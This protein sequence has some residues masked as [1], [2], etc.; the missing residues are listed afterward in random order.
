VVARPVGYLYARTDGS[1]GFYQKT[2]GTGNTGWSAIGGSD[3][4]LGG[5]LGGTASA[6]TVLALDGTAG[7]VPGPSGSDLTIRAALGKAAYLQAKGGGGPSLSLEANGSVALQA[8]SGAGTVAAAANQNLY[9]YANE[10]GGAGTG[11]VVV[12]DTGI[13]FS[14]NGDARLYRSGTKTATFDDGAGGAATFAITGALT[15]TGKVSCVAASFR[16]WLAASQTITT[17]TTT[18]LA[19]WTEK[20]DNGSAFNA[21]TGEFTAPVTGYYSFTG[22]ADFLSAS[23]L[24]TLFIYNS[25]TSKELARAQGSTT[26]D[27]TGLVTGENLCTAGDVI[28]FRVSHNKGSN[29]DVYGQAGEH[30][31]TTFCGHLIAGQ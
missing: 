24:P 6:A 29:N 18:T 5:S 3:P 23:T 8:S 31:Y 20:Y 19:G 14:S 30:T 28:V 27:T 21:S 10:S 11:S 13:K 1:G 16:A 26:A 7:V 15:T 2:S 25:T 12:G 4:T 22:T 9:L 17:G